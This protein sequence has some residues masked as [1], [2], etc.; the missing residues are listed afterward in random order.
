M[1]VL[2][3]YNAKHIQIGEPLELEDDNYFCKIS[4]NNA[5][6]IL[7][8]NKVCYYKNRKSSKHVYISVTSKEYLEW[9]ENFYRVS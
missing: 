3:F 7:K 4:Y 2:D 5:P 6:F 1:N 9:F 8:T